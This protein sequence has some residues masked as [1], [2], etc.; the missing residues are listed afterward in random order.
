[1]NL[2]TFSICLSPFLT[3]AHTVYLSLHAPQVALRNMKER[4][5]KL[6][7]KMA[8]IEDDNQRLITGKSE[9]FGEIGKLQ[10]LSSSL[11]EHVLFSSF[12]WCFLY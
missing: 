9:L 2:Q 10:V 8:L 7:K 4:Y 11:L 12:K 5:H 1:M 6:Q 3:P